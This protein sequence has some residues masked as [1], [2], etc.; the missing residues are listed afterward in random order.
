[1]PQCSVLGPL[2][3]LLYTS[4]IFSILP[5]KLISYADDSTLMAVCH[6]QGLGL[7]LSSTWSAT[8]ARIV[9]DV[10]FGVWN[11]IRVKIRQW[12]S[13]GR[14]QCIPM[15]SPS[16]T[17][18]RTVLMESADLDILEVPFDTKMTFEKH[19]RSFPE[20]LKTWYLEP[21]LTSV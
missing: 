10:T 11:W 12:W 20:Q 21:V 9:S 8:S 13:P 17:I 2:L 4:E 7:Q 5:N 19:L 16:L 18:G 15:Q 3:F 1:M 6:P 14:A